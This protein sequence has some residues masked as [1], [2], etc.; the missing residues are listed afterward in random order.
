MKT[1][2]YFLLFFG[3]ALL[4]IVLVIILGD[5]APWYFAWIIGTGLLILT[6]AASGFL[7]DTQS[8]DPHEAEQTPPR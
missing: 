7:Y 2:G 5:S 4:L 6:S 3:L 8:E 1:I